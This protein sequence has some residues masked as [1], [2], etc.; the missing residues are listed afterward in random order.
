MAVLTLND[1]TFFTLASVEDLLRQAKGSEEEQ[2]IIKAAHVQKAAWLKS[3]N[4]IIVMCYELDY[5]PATIPA[6]RIFLYN[7]EQK[8]EKKWRAWGEH[9]KNG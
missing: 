3:K 1:V 7:S 2:H 6:T 9:A 4:W 8:V 5:S